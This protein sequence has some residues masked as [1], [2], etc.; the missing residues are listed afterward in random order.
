MLSN[1]PD[2]LIGVIF[3]S[4]LLGLAILAGGRVNAWRKARHTRAMAPLAAIIGGTVASDEASATISGT[5]R[6]RKVTARMTPG[7]NISESSEYITRINSFEVILPDTPGEHSWEIAYEGLLRKKWVFKA[8]DDGLKERL[9]QSRLLSDLDR[10][11][12]HPSIQFDARQGTLW[13]HEDIQPRQA[14]TAERFQA[15]L[16]LLDALADLN[17]DLNNP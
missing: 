12:N 5:F 13:F 17:Q 14:P 11:G 2:L 4:A 10:H 1:L 9:S 3:F 6:N 15:Q 7:R 16:R 8:Q